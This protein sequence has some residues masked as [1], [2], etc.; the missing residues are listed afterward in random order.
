[1]VSIYQEMQIEDVGIWFIS[2][3][4]GFKISIKLPSNAV[5]SILKGCDVEFV[6]G[7]DEVNGKHYFHTGVRIYDVIKNPLIIIQPSRIQ[8]DY[9]GLKRLLNENDVIIEFYD[10]LLVCSAT[11]QLSIPQNT[12]NEL[13]DF[14]GDI[15]S[16]YTGE[17]DT[18]LSSSLDS[19][20]YTLDNS[21]KGNKSYEILSKY[22]KCNLLNLKAINTVYVGLIDSHNVNVSNIDEGSNFE[23][24]IWFSMESLFN[25]C[26][27]LNP[28]IQENEKKRELTD[29]LAYYQYGIFL[30]ETKA[31]GIL[32]LE[33]NQE[34]DR[35]I[36][37]LKKQITKGIK[38]LI[39]ANKNMERQLKILNNVGLT[40]E[41]NRN[42]V[43]HCI[44]LVSDLL[45]FG[46]WDDIENLINETIK[47]EKIYL[48]VMDFMEFTKFLKMS[49]GKR[50]HFDYYLMERAEQY[51]KVQN[52][53]MRTDFKMA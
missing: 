6:F 1:M 51:S 42:L 47:T 49:K 38:Q 7:K 27:H 2:D 14:L 21:Q 40:I 50:E 30:I 19:F 46:N 23:K 33:K 31:L 11:A 44:V 5:R 22:Y 13:L 35:K 28:I 24:Q 48:H 8:R 53:H 37:N 43:P 32:N 20:H 12:R 39:G 9:T 34:M 36:A 26:I 25:E 41:F 17:Y 45:A 16:F 4:S 10:E 3:D 52:I 18:Q 15:N 29:I